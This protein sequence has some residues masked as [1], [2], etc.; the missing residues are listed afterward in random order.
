M[1]SPTGAVRLYVPA[2]ALDIHDRAARGR[3]SRASVLGRPQAADGAPDQTFAR[4]RLDRPQYD[5]MSTRAAWARAATTGAASDHASWRDPRRGERAQHV[6]CGPPISKTSSGRAITRTAT[7]SPSPITPRASCSRVMDCVPP[8]ANWPSR[9]S[10]ARLAVWRKP[11]TGCGRSTSKRSCWPRWTNAITS[12]RSDPRVKHVAGP[13]CQSC[14]RPFTCAQTLSPHR[15]ALHGTARR[16]ITMPS[17]A[18]I[19]VPPII[20]TAAP[21]YSSFRP[22]A[23]PMIPPRTAPQSN[24]RRTTARRSIRHGSLPCVT[25]TDPALRATDRSDEGAG[26]ACVLTGQTVMVVRFGACKNG[27]IIRCASAHRGARTMASAAI[28]IATGCMKIGVKCFISFR[29]WWSGLTKRRSAALRRRR[30]CS[31]AATTGRKV[32]SNAR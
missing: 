8:R 32:S 15:S 3:A 19:T 27:A 14:S 6:F 11:T 4:S 7:C 5:R 25:E 13:K 23:Y 20:P 9:S 1:G 26:C 28:Q 2:H 18:P 30:S 10:S 29:C 21:P 24:P 17:G 12:F 16:P 22:A 31:C